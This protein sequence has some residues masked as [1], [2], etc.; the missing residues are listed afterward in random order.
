MMHVRPKNS[1]IIINRAPAHD[2]NRRSNT[3]MDEEVSLLNISAAFP[4]GI[5]QKKDD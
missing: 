1:E 4:N 2:A 5:A 3:V